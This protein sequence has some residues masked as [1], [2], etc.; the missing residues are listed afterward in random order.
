MGTDIHWIIERKHTDGTWE[1][2]LCKA[3]VFWQ[4]H[5]EHRYDK[6]WLFTDPAMNLLSRDYMLFSILSDINEEMEWSDETLA[7]AGLPVDASDYTAVNYADDGDMHSH[8]YIELGRLMEAANGSSLSHVVP[9][10]E[11]RQLIKDLVERLENLAADQDGKRLEHIMIGKSYGD[12]EGDGDD[13]G[14]WAMRSMSA[15]EKVSMIE[16]AQGFLPIGPDTLRLV[17]A[18]D[19]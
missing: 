16:R 2:A 4:W 9:E 8:G 7:K 5:H 10:P 15:H 17:I 6:D 12:I 13:E 19:N 11:H 3:Y 1:A 14:F 18:Y